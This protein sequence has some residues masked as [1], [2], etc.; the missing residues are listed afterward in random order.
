MSRYYVRKFKDEDKEGMIA[1]FEEVWTKELADKLREMWEWKYEKNPHD[2]P[3]GNT[4][5]VLERDGRI[6]G[7]L[8][9]LSGLVKLK[10][11]TLPMLWA[12]DFAIH[13]D[14]RGGG[15]RILNWAKKEYSSFVQGGIVTAGRP[16][17]FYKKMRY[18]PVF[19][20]SIFKNILNPKNFFRKKT[21]NIAVA[22]IIAILFK[23]V[24][25]FLSLFKIHLKDKN[26]SVS[27]ISGFDDRF[28]ALWKEASEGYTIC[29]VRDKDFLNWRF[30][31]RPDQGYTIF[32]AEKRGKIL[33]YI[34]LNHQSQ[35]NKKYGS[36]IDLFTKKNDKK[37]LHRLIAQA[38]D[39]FK[40]E[41][42]DI[43]SFPMPPECGF[44][45]NVLIK[46]GFFVRTKGGSFVASPA[47]YPEIE[48]DLMKP[49]N[50]FLTSM[51]SDMER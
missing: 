41:R 47:G 42:V 46:N 45:R 21:K 23:L 31:E 39:Y 49:K 5:C 7:M 1:L 22:Y 11:R 8:G 2:P 9:L 18:L 15:F 37:T 27:K 35:D 16:Y 12:I 6:I 10:G 17:E 26:I 4:T 33:G 24:S 51:S 3:D 20:F 19:S 43:A 29:M 14:F 48:K 13:P 44:Y 32:A 25:G 34:V 28:D 50:W 36:I 38:L 40:S 30:F